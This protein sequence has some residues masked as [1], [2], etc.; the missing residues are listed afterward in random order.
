MVSVSPA[1]PAVTAVGRE[2]NCIL[3]SG[4]VTELQAK[5][6]QAA[7]RELDYCSVGV[8]VREYSTV[9]TTDNIVDAGFVDLSLHPL[10]LS[11]VGC[12]IA[13]GTAYHDNVLTHRSVMSVRR[14]L[15]QQRVLLLFVITLT[16]LHAPLRVQERCSSRHCMR[17]SA[18]RHQMHCLHS[19]QV[20]CSH[21]RG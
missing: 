19:H 8:H 17:C 6:L 3:S 15:P 4:N 18:L 20:G 14:H 1:E 11:L 12:V 2:I 5:T 16:G 10:R 13:R 7:F 21:V 9:I